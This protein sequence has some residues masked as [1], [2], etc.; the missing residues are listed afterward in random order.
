MIKNFVLIPFLYLNSIYLFIYYIGLSRV[1]IKFYSQI[2]VMLMRLLASDLFYCFCEDQE[3]MF[4]LYNTYAITWIF[5]HCSK[6]ITLM[7]FKLWIRF[8]SKFWFND[9]LGWVIAKFIANIT[10]QNKSKDLSIEPLVKN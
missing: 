4:E 7:I 2:L 3:M 1:L 5:I 9:W 8:L 6:T 10:L